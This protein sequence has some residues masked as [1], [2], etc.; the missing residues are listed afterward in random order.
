M[1]SRFNGLS[2]VFAIEQAGKACSNLASFL[3]CSSCR[4]LLTLLRETA[5]KRDDVMTLTFSVPRGKE[6]SRLKS[7][8]KLVV[9]GGDVEPISRSRHPFRTLNLVFS[10]Y[11]HRYSVV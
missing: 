10:G 2:R 9:Y 11:E 6:I 8:T 4:L 5:R 3:C 7:P 1:E